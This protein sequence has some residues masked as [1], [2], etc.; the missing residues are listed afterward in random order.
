M[1]KHLLTT[2]LAQAVYHVLWYANIRA[3]AHNHTNI[4]LITDA[5]SVV[6]YAFVL[7]RVL[8]AEALREWV[9]MFVGGILGSWVG[10][11][12]PLV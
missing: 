8:Q 11:H 7:K 6:L 5:A 2:A 9:A 4:A 1:Y 10:L 12:L 3:T